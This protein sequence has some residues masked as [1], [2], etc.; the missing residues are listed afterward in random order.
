MKTIEEY[1]K[2]LPGT[3]KFPM[4]DHKFAFLPIEEW[5]EDEPFSQDNNEMVWSEEERE[6]CLCIYKDADG[7]WE[8]SYTAFGVEGAEY[9]LPLFDD[10]IKEMQ[11]EGCKLY[12]G[13]IYRKDLQEALDILWRWLENKKII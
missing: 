11:E 10:Q 7:S 12:L 6:Y 9:S 4:F 3:I 13:G 1:L 8:V 2:D 5:G